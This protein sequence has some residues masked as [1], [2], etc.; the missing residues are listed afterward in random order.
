M[1]TKLSSKATRDLGRSRARYRPYTA[2]AYADGMLG[3]SDSLYVKRNAR[4]KKKNVSSR[5]YEDIDYSYERMELRDRL[6]DMN[7]APPPYADL[8]ERPDLYSNPAAPYTNLTDEAYGTKDQDQH[9][10]QD[11]DQD[12]QVDDGT[13]DDTPIREPDTNVKSLEEWERDYKA[14]DGTY[15]TPINL[16][17]N[18]FSGSSVLNDDQWEYLSFLVKSMKPMTGWNNSEVWNLPSR[19]TPINIDTKTSNYLL[20]GYNV[21]PS[22]P[23]SSTNFKNFLVNINTYRQQEPGTTPDQQFN[24]DLGQFDAKYRDPSSQADLFFIPKE[25]FPPSYYQSN[26]NDGAY[27]FLQ[28]YIRF[29]AKNVTLDRN[30]STY[31]DYV[32]KIDHDY[33]RIAYTNPGSKRELYLNIEIP[34]GY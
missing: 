3:P 6:L 24:R 31:V 27:A 8:S 11:Q 30:A 1:F 21:D 26:L 29:Y 14:D 18:N 32:R 17:P 5:R 9:Q 2:H 16:F 34:K 15:I 13:E 25:F 12:N 23:F 10:D 4:D 22:A 7:P 33:V 19:D 20:F 28:D